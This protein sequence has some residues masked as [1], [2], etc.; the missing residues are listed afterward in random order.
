MRLKALGKPYIYDL[1]DNFF[2][3]SLNLP[4]GIYH[5]APERIMQL[6]TYIRSAGLVRVYSLTLETRVKQYTTKVKLLQA[7]V[8]LSSIPLTPPV[9]N[10]RKVRIVFSTSRT[11]EDELS[12]I[13]VQDLKRVLSEYPNEVEAHFWGY[14]PKSL[15]GIPSVKFH[16]FI[17]NYSKYLRTFYS[18]GYDIGLAPMKDDVFHNS[19]T[20]N[21]FREYGACWVAGIYSNSEVYAD[22]VQDGVTGLLVSNKQGAWYEALKR[23]I[24]D[25]Q[26]RYD[27][28]NNAR[29]FVERQYG[30]DLFAFSLLKDIYE[31]Y[32]VY[33]EQDVPVE[34]DYELSSVSKIERQS[35]NGFKHFFVK[36]IAR[37][38]RAFNYLRKYGF[39]HTFRLVI[40]LLERYIRYFLLTWEIMRKHNKL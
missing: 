36:L 37:M 35:S 11:I 9:R 15:R 12:E 25:E 1:D 18:S 39:W 24:L 31:V 33:M 34:L 29:S 14:M 6:E 8:N 4:E 10:S 3:I 30:L 23:L 22:C 19:K 16:R 5:R 28:Q 26:L 13:F 17:A 38:N 20:N 7:P 27:I 2:E 21:K 32:S 40:E